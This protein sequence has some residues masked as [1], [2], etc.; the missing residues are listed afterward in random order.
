MTLPKTSCDHQEIGC[1]F[2]YHLNHSIMKKFSLFILMA[3]TLAGH[4][5]LGGKL[6]QKYVEKKF[7][8]TD[9]T[10]LQEMSFYVDGNMS[11]SVNNIPDGTKTLIIK[12]PINK[13]AND[14]K[15]MGMSS[16]FTW[17]FN[18]TIMK[19]SGDP[20]QVESVMFT[21]NDNIENWSTITKGDGYLQFELDKDDLLRPMKYV[22]GNLQTQ[23]LE[24]KCELYTICSKGS[25]F[26]NRST[27]TIAS[28]GPKGKWSTGTLEEDLAAYKPGGTR[29]QANTK[30]DVFLRML[31]H[32][33]ETYPTADI[34]HLKVMS[35]SPTDDGRLVSDIWV[36]LSENGKCAEYAV[37]VWE[38]K[39]TLSLSNYVPQV[40]HDLSDAFCNRKEEIRNVK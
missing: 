14:L 15:T 20:E 18:M 22:D 16:E 33:K 23:T 28:E 1:Y 21:K 17:V 4:A 12:C 24:V 13:G 9:E 35:T 37:A 40:V 29:Y 11:S 26:L 30:S 32:T 8:G 19:H 38:D 34:I 6:A 5:Q 3:L 39:Y 2:A 25:S 27:I 10:L 7:S 36:T 31:E